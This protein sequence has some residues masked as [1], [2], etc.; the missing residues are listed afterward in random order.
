[1]ILEKRAGWVQAILAT[2]QFRMLHVL[3]YKT[4]IFPF[5]LFGCE[6]WCFVSREEHR[7]RVFESRVVWRMM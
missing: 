5:I 6:I 3:M 7:L 4:E 2:I 1:M